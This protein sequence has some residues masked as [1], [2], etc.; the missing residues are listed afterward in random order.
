MLYELRWSETF[1]LF[2]F[3]VTFQFLSLTATHHLFP[4]VL[5]QK[6]PRQCLPGMD[7]GLWSWNKSQVSNHMRPSH[8]PSSKGCRE[9]GYLCPQSPLLLL[10]LAT[11][12]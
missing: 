1:C 9:G 5:Q 6:M 12:A 10:W 11:E 3:L 8:S 4:Q 7:S 2:L